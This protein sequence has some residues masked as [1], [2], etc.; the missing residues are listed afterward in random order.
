[1]TVITE[2]GLEARARFLCGDTPVAAFTYIA[3]GTG[4]GAES[5]ADTTLGTEITDTGL[6]RAAATC[7]YVADYIARWTKTFSATGS[8]T[9]TEVG[10][11]NDASAGTM[12]L[13]K[14]FDAGISVVNGQDITILIEDTQS[15]A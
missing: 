3:L 14:K 1:M 12:Y 5:T 15:Q 11:F 9:I 6:Q 10:L 7:S 2:L 8:K 13:R 4:T